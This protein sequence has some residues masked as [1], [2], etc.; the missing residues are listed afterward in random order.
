MERDP[1][2]DGGAGAAPTLAILGAGK[3]GENLIRGWLAAETVD[4]AR[5]LVT[6]G[7]QRRSRHLAESL[8]VEAVV[9]NREAAARADIVLLCVKPQMAEVVLAQ[10]SDQLHEDQLLISVL[11]SVT[12]GYIERRLQRR[13]P[14]VRVMPNTP[15]RVRE[16]MSAVCGGQWAQE[17]HLER[18]EQLFAPLG[19]VLRIEEKHFD[20]VT[21]LS[22]S[23]PAFLYV[24]IEALAEG[25]V[26]VGLPRAVATELAAQSCLGAAR[27]VLE[28]GSHPALLKDEVTTPAGCTVDGILRLEEGGLR[29]TL[30]KAIVEAQARASQLVQE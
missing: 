10:I 11:A 12:T 20:A 4:P 23:G 6:A 18:A 28:T 5:V 25:G 24:V 2:R 3:M 21:G 8:E 15:S 7:H 22:A 17:E 13:V 26:K 30:I 27:M 16:G 14:V 9:G 19:R 1:K 29:V